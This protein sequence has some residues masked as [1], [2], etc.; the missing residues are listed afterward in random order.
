MHREKLAFFITISL[1]ILNDKLK[2]S[3]FEAKKNYFTV[4]V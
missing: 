3:M 2:F 1:C 4:N